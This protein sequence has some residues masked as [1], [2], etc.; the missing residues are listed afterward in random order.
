V[1]RAVKAGRFKLVMELD[2]G[3][4]EL[5]D[6]EA[7]PGETRNVAADHP[8]EVQR[9]QRALSTRLREVEGVADAGQAVRRGEEASERLRALGYLE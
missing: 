7:D 6:L 9:L 4:V 5:Y 2:S 1:L 3:E 8:R